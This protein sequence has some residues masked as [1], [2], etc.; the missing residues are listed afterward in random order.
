M[1]KFAALGLM[2]LMST[3]A[4]GVEA[5]FVYSCHFFLAKGALCGKIPG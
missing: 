3:A 2:A 1:K 4:Q 5:S